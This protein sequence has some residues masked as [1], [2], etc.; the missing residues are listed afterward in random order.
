MNCQVLVKIKTVTFHLPDEWACHTIRPIPTVWPR[1]PRLRGARVPVFVAACALAA[2]APGQ[3]PADLSTPST[4]DAPP[5]TPGSDPSASR[6]SS[7]PS[8]T[9]EPTTEPTTDASLVTPGGDPPT[10]PSRS[11]P[12]GRAELT[13]DTDSP[14]IP[15]D[16][17]LFGTNVPAWLGPEVLGADWFRAALADAG[18]TTVRMPGGSWSNT[19]PWDACELRRPECWAPNSARPSDFAALLESTGLE[20]MWT[21]SANATA[22]SAA[23]L[24]AFFNGTVADARPIGTD[25][26]GIDWGTVGTW[27]ELRASGGHPQPVPI[28]RWEIGNEVWGGRPDAGGEQ[29]ADF[30]WEDVWTCDGTEYMEGD[31]DHDGFLAVRDAMRAVDPTIEVGA[32]GVPSPGDWSDWGHEVLEHVGSIDFYVVHEYGFVESPAAADAAAGPGQRWADVAAAAAPALGAERLAV[33]EYNLVSFEAGDTEHMMTTAANAFFL[34]DTLGRFAS[35]GIGAANHWNMANGTTGSGTDYGLVDLNEQRRFPA[36]SAFAA[37][38]LAGSELLANPA[39]ES[40]PGLTV[41]PTKHA[42]GRVA[43]IVLNP[44]EERAVDWQALGTDPTAPTTQVAFV[45]PSL[46]S[47]SMERVPDV[48]LDGPAGTLELAAHSINVITIG[49]IDD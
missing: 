45:A 10:G 47:R 20:G 48:E 32:V 1:F 24:V 37:W 12:G 42:D 41:Y 17:R 28:L 25:R 23:A 3:R 49:H 44:G 7:T 5:I 4:A 22:E 46:E 30:G 31:G 36:F 13:I 11:T 18:V 16:P 33:T 38:A 43:V 15:I 21:V 26:D 29:C 8:G 2:C 40:V 34:A 27:A 14:T 35:A 19:Y 9:A 6:S 39:P